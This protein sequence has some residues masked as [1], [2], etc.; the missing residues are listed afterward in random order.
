MPPAHEHLIFCLSPFIIPYEY[1]RDVLT[2]L[3]RATNKQVK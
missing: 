2:R 3:P 1:L